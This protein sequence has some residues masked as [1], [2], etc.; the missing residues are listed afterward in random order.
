MSPSAS[1]NSSPRKRIPSI[2]SKGSPAKTITHSKQMQPLR[3][4]VFT[5]VPWVIWYSQWWD[6]NWGGFEKVLVGKTQLGCQEEA[7]NKIL[8][9]CNGATWLVI[10][11]AHV[12]LSQISI[13]VVLGS[14]TCLEKR[15][16]L[17]LC[18]FDVLY[19]WAWHYNGRH[20]W[21]NT[22]Q[23]IVNMNIK[24]FFIHIEGP[25][26]QIWEIYLQNIAEICIMMFPLVY[27]HLPLPPTTMFLQ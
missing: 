5:N 27:N 26:C 10:T 17:F 2:C 16:Q 13:R 25:V 14:M 1:L 23:L 18:R 9:L 7:C 20:W 19:L 21:R 22:P 3:R 8:S 15:I 6:C 12:E 24:Q 4:C 11:M